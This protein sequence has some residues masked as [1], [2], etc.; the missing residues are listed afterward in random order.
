MRTSEIIASIAVAGCVATFAVL[1]LNESSTSGSSFLATPIGEVERAF[2]SFCA[3]Y[4]R[5]FGT[6]EEYAFRL[7][8]FEQTYH[9]V[10]SHNM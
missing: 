8:Q 1:N 4:H 6:K 7:A 9:N 10:M 2:I 3:K 5:T